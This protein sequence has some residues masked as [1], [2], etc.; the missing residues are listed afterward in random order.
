MPVL[1]A[2]GPRYT[3]WIGFFNVGSFVDGLPHCVESTDGGATCTTRSSFVSY[4]PHNSAML[5][6]PEALWHPPSGKIWVGGSRGITT[7]GWTG[8]SVE[9]AY[10]TD[11][12]H[13]HYDSSPDFA[14]LT[15][16]GSSPQIWFDGWARMP[17]QDYA[18]VLACPNAAVSPLQCYEYIVPVDLTTSPATFG[19]PI[20]PITGAGLPGSMLNPQMMMIGGTIYLFEKNDD[21]GQKNYEVYTNSSVRA[22]S[23]TVVHGQSAGDPDFLGWGRPREALAYLELPDRLRAFLDPEGAGMKYSDNFT[24]NPLVNEWTAPANITAPFQMQHGNFVPNPF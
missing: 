19:T 5:G 4:T 24:K 16:G 7:T 14:A 23:W 1:V 15:A 22:G 9:I 8:T 12:D 3:K 20:G 18:F 17:G 6:C 13:L 2:P 11:P 10:M 21:S